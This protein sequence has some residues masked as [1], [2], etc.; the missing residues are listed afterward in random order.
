MRRTWRMCR[1]AVNFLKSSLAHFWYCLM[2]AAETTSF[3]N[4]RCHCK[5]KLRLV[6]LLGNLTIH[7]K[8]FLS[9]LMG[10][11]HLVV[12]GHLYTSVKK[13]ANLSCAAGPACLLLIGRGGGCSGFNVNFETGIEV[14]SLLHT[15]TGTL[16]AISDFIFQKNAGTSTQDLTLLLLKQ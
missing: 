9:Q 7:L 12:M 3:L 11:T 10:I 13:E 4:S 8:I 16:A 15:V 2:W 14:C 6:G 1:I 5:L